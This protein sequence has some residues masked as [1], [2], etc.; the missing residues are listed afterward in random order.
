MEL[1][2]DDDGGQK[3]NTQTVKISIELTNINI[4]YFL[5]FRN[6]GGQNTNFERVN[7]EHVNFEHVNFDHIVKCQQL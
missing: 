4:V 5:C 1:V 6:D 3:E 2:N 7:F